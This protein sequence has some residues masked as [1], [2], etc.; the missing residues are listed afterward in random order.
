[1][2]ILN[3]TKWLFSLLQNNKLE[4]IPAGVFDNMPNLRELYLQNNFLS[5]GGLDN[6]TFRWT[7]QMQKFKYKYFITS[8]LQM[9]VFLSV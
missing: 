2:S 6:D 8:W 5:N 9:F 7:K 4:K 3:V 1:M